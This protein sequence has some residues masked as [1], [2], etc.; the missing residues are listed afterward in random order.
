[1]NGV[2][3]AADQLQRFCD[4]QGWHYCLI[5]GL[6]VQRWG[7]PRV[8]VDVDVTLLTGLGNE[9]AYVEAL[10]GRFAAR[11]PDAREFALRWRVLLLQTAGGV[12]LDISLGALPFE[13]RA[14]ARSSPGQFGPDLWLRTC[15]AEDLIV[16]KA[17]ASRE[18]DWLDV[19]TVLIRQGTKL[20]WPQITEELRS[21]CDLA[22]KPDVPGR[23]ERLRQSVSSR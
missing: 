20:N 6:A 21:L 8:T 1:M 17:L 15:S 9:E 22:E 23:L 13:E 18:Q 14:I 2:F 19:K 10:L 11:R 12:G 7:Q 4:A 5:G 16:M 3:Q